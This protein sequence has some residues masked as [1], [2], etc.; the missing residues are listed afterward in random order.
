[1]ESNRFLFLLYSGSI[2]V[3]FLLTSNALGMGLRSYDS[4]CAFRKSNVTFGHEELY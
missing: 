1:M 4:H 2:L 3:H